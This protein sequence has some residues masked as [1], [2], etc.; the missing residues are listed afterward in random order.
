MF[1]SKCGTENPDNGKF[2][3]SCGLPINGGTAVAPAMP[4]QLQRLVD[5][6]GKPISYESALAKIFTGIAFIVI[7]CFLYFT[8]AAG[9]HAWGFWMLIPGFGSLGSGIAQWLQIRNAGAA[10]VNV[11]PI[12]DPN[13]GISGAAATPNL[14]PAQQQWVSPDSTYRTGDLVPPSVTDATTRHL[15]TDS[16]GQ[17]MTLPSDKK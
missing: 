9:G 6:K 3:R 13:R 5:K 4:P 7:A 2:C 17:T 1:C 8:N 12:V 11:A 10:G 14:P 15:Q 16:E